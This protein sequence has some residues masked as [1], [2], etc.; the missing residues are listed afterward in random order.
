LREQLKLNRQNGQK[1]HDQTTSSESTAL[2]MG[3]MLPER[4]SN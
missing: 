2:R 1:E 3:P 4:I